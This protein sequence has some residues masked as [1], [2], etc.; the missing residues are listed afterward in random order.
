M[1]VH[2]YCISIKPS[3]TSITWQLYCK[4][5]KVSNLFIRDRRMNL[6]VRTDG[7]ADSGCMT[8]AQIN[9]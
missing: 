7:L 6:R 1:K 5:P 9:P 2:L 4:Y 3:W 8:S